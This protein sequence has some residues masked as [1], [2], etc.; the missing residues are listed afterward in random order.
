MNMPVCIIYALLCSVCW[1]T[2]S[3]RSKIV[4]SKKYLAIPLTGASLLMLVGIAIVF[5]LFFIFKQSSLSIAFKLI[6]I[7]MILLLILYALYAL[8]LIKVP[9]T[10]PVLGYGLL[11]GIVWAA[12]MF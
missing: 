8:Y 7:A 3:I 10:I 5:I 1:G 12:G 9:I 2:Y 11:Q 4:T 6:S